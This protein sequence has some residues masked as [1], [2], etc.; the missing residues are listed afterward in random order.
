MISHLELISSADGT[1]KYQPYFCVDLS[2]NPSNSD[3]YQ[4]S[5]GSV[6][7]SA[8]KGLLVY[9]RFLD[10]D[11]LEQL[12]A[13]LTNNALRSVLPLAN[14]RTLFAEVSYRCVGGDAEVPTLTA[15]QQQSS[16][17][18]ADSLSILQSVA[19]AV[20]SIED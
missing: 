15:G 19:S 7:A 9:Q 8:G 5:G 6:I 3:F 4:L 20:P 13:W 17:Y 11:S 18:Y 12:Q 16:S 14:G 10:I 1:P 2:V